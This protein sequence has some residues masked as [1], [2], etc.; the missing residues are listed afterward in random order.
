[1]EI[2]RQV[3]LGKKRVQEVAIA[4][5]KDVSQIYRTVR[6]LQKKRFAKLEGKIIVPFQNTHVTLLLQELS[7]RPAIVRLL[8]GSGILL[9][10]A[11][12]EPKS[13][14]E[15]LSTTGM[16]RSTMFHLLKEASKNS[17]FNTVKNKHSFNEKIWPRVKDFLTELKH[18]E[19]TTDERTPPGAITYFK[20]DSEILFSTKTECDASLTGFSAYE[21][22]GISVLPVDYTY[23]LPKKKLTKKE[24]FNHSL[25][26]AEKEGDARDIIIIT[27]F[28][29]KHKKELKM[30]RHE[31]VNNIQK[32]LKG[33]KV[34]NYPTLN[35][36]KERA[37]VYDIHI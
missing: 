36:I 8:S 12:L 4:L 3:A 11:L 2:L 10:T 28:Y 25:Y 9:S 24:V 5:R 18:Y 31:I 20:N 14:P 34:I 7:R 27:I 16:K 15:L 13:V 30:I 35:E 26:R 22:Y 1:M 32:I 33:E 6:T 21:H 17:F 29:L 19:E 37:N 23:Y